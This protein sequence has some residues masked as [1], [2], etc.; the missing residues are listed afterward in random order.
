[1]INHLVRLEITVTNI[2]ALHIGSG[3]EGE[4]SDDGVVTTPRGEPFLPGSSLKGKLRATAERLAGHLNLDAC[5]LDSTYSD[6][7]CCN[8]QTWARQ[9]QTTLD[10]IRSEKN[11]QLKLEK[12]AEVTCDVC[13]VFGSPLQASRITITDGMVLEW[14]KTV[15]VRDGVVIDRDA[16][17]A[18]P[19]L[20]FNYDVIPAG[21][22]F[23]F[24]VELHDLDDDELALIGAALLDWSSGFTLGGHISRGLGHMRIE[25]VKA[26]QINL[27][28]PNDRLQYLVNRKMNPIADW[29]TYFQDYVN[30]ILKEEASYA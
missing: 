25:E 22:L 11:S 8:C 29:A 1:M 13:R 28:D 24:T 6:V 2:T 17:T 5:L 15:Q 10:T 27:S 3:R 7:E 23:Q 12:I 4:I 18:V 20:K 19:R 16:E 21:A 14:E 26:E 30:A 9:N